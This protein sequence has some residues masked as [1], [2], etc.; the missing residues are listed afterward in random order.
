MSANTFGVAI[1]T[2][3]A[4]LPRSRQCSSESHL[5]SL[6]TFPYEQKIHLVWGL[7]VRQDLAKL[8]ASFSGL[9]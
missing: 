8:A 6:L 5:A 7:R 9:I 2:L 4:R 3:L 1:N